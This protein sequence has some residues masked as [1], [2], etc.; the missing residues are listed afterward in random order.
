M[1]PPPTPPDSVAP[2][3]KPP[4]DTQELPDG[5]DLSDFND[6]QVAG[7]GFSDDPPPKPLEEKLAP[8]EPELL[9]PPPALPALEITAPTLQP[10]A[11]PLPPAPVV[12]AAPQEPAPEAAPPTPAPEAPPPPPQ[13]ERMLYVTPPQPIQ[14]VSY[15]MYAPNPYGYSPYATAP[16]PYPVAA[17]PG[18]GAPVSV[19]GYATAPVTYGPYYPP[20]GFPAPPANRAWKTKLGGER[21]Q[22]TALIGFSAFALSA[23]VRLF[24]AGT[25]LSS[26]PGSSEFATFG[27]NFLF[28]LLLFFEAGGFVVAAVAGGAAVLGL[29]RGA[30]EIAA[31]SAEDLK[32]GA[33]L[34]GVALGLPVAAF[35]AQTLYLTSVQAALPGLGVGS[36]LGLERL[37][38]NYRLA[39]AGAAL[40]N[41]AAAFLAVRGLQLST[42]GL[43]PVKGRNDFS[44][45]ARAFVIG[46]AASAAL[47]IIAYYLVIVPPTLE[48]QASPASAQGLLAVG[49][50]IAMLSFLWL[51]RAA[52]YIGP[53][54]ERI[55]SAAPPEKPK[56]EAPS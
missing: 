10:E 41:V 46:A 53:E 38:D 23:L 15:P 3:K 56:S 43:L 25:G 44:R 16:F 26:I 54:A 48:A 51:R 22:T 32:R 9:R 18:Y 1:S 39:A 35:A 50:A 11:A 17:A 12:E 6:D 5:I 7:L 34:L 30:K 52:G 36:D 20:Q 31:P 29:R 47:T 14:Y 2:K 40:I 45:F 13:D 24:E 28:Q 33:V 4:I 55:A 8:P 37:Y 42:R 27:V 21:L 49:P 19:P